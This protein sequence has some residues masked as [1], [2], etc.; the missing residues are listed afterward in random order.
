MSMNTTEGA[1]YCWLDTNK[2]SPREKL[3]YGE[4]MAVLPGLIETRMVHLKKDKGPWVPTSDIVK[5]MLHKSADGAEEEKSVEL[6]RRKKLVGIMYNVV[7]R[8]GANDDM[9]KMP[10]DCMVSRL[11]NEKSG[12]EL[13]LPKYVKDEV[14]AAAK[15]V[16]ILFKR[17]VYEGNVCI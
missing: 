13:S 17:A 7:K 10:P 16:P 1:E 8:K 6:Q 5:V 3:F 9:S 2:L 11:K 14:A 15:G 12:H 4:V